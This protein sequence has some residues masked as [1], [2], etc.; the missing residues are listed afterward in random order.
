M[1]RSSHSTIEFQKLAHKD[2]ALWKTPDEK[3]SYLPSQ[4]FLFTLLAS[5]LSIASQE[6]D[7]SQVQCKGL[8]SMRDNPPSNLSKVDREKK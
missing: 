2:G 6:S 3:G 5:K 7:R 4:N 8:K 1:E